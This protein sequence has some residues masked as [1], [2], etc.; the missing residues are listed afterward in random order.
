MRLFLDRLA[1]AVFKFIYSE[2]SESQIDSML[3]KVFGLKADI[4]Y[5]IS[6]NNLVGT[7]DLT[8]DEKV[9]VDSNGMLHRV[10]MDSELIVKDN[11]LYEVE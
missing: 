1:E 3:K 8:G 4:K 10:N 7:G 5:S 9:Y 6:N 2:P 11:Y